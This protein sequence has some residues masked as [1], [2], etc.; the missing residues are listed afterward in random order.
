MSNSDK[1]IWVNAFHKEA[2]V[3][4][5]MRDRGWA[6]YNA[7]RPIPGDKVWESA[8]RHGV[9]YAAGDVDL[10]GKTWEKL[11]A[12]PVQVIT[13]DEII[14]RLRSHAATHPLGDRFEEFVRRR[15]YKELAIGW[16]KLPFLEVGDDS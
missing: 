2:E 15:G 8:F 1:I 13:N 5:V 9:F 4:R 11:D 6:V 3:F 14:A 16:L 12:W 7:P 10:F